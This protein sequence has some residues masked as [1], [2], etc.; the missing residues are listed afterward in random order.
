MTEKDKFKQEI[1]QAEQ[2]FAKM[3]KEQG[4]QAGF[5]F[6]ADSNAVIRRG[7]ETLIKG[8]KAIEE[9]YSNPKY[10]DVLLVWE[11]DFVDVAES[12][13]LGYTYGHYTFE[14]KDSL[15]NPIKAEGTFHTVWKRQ[16]DGTWKY[17]WD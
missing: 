12:G 5:T 7:D 17:V 14:A 15:G 11:A 4:M 16:S 10:K 2:D 13:D 3:V 9:N 8:K 1:V 6:Y